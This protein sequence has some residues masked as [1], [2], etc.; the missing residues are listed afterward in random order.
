MYFLMISAKAFAIHYH[1]GQTFVHLVAFYYSKNSILE[2]FYNINELDFEVLEIC[3]FEVLVLSQKRKLDF[4][5]LLPLT[6]SYQN[7]AFTRYQIF[8]KSFQCFTVSDV[9]KKL[10]CCCMK[11]VASHSG[12]NPSEIIRVN[13]S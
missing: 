7:R 10:T 2:Y 13:I 8:T 4:G 9:H 11:N 3:P 12:A 5:I 1:F 6:E